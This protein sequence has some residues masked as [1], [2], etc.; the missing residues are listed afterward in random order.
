MSHPFQSLPQDK[1]GKAFWPLFAVTIILMIALNL[2]G[3]PTNTPSAPYGI[4][5]YE[6]AGSVQKSLEILNSWDVYTK[7]SAAFSLG[8]DFLFMVA[9]S[10][11][12]AL[13]CVWSARVLRERDLPFASLGAPLA[14]GQWLAAILDAVEN[15]AL[16]LILFNFMHAGAVGA[17][18]P[19]IARWSAIFKFGLVFLG[20]VY[21]FFG[22]AIRLFVKSH[23]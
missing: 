22:G 7:A 17:P 11:T 21:T 1:F 19:Q 18:W 5:S 2:V 12:I 6:L 13:G 9:Y 15:I 20:L 16:L 23:D 10:C 3:G 4:I 14:W 8:L